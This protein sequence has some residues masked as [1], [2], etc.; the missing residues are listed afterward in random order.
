MKIYTVEPSHVAEL[1]EEF[2]SHY[3][4]DVFFTNRFLIDTDM[5]TGFT[6]PRGERTVSVDEIEVIDEDGINHQLKC[7]MYLL[8][9]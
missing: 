9:C 2:E 8:E 5:L 7:L 6:V 1:R 3:E 4:A